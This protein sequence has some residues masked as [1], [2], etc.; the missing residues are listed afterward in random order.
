MDIDI[1]VSSKTRPLEIF[2][3]IVPASLNENGVLRKHNVGYYFQPIPIDDETGLSAITYKNAPN[4]NY[5]KIDIIPVRL[6]D[7]FSS[8]Q[9]LRELMHKEP[10]W[11]LLEERK[12]VEQ[13]FH[14]HD[15]FDIVYKIKPR[16]ILE[17]ADCLALIRPNK[18]KLIDKYVKSKDKTIIRKEL[19]KK[20]DPSDLRK[21]HAIPYAYLIIAQLNLIEREIT[22]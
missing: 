5:F 4:F 8:K 22:E 12:V 3:H 10:I 15:K 6:L 1:D 14:L 13:L 19:Y 11:E 20:H 18:V 7:S 2:D 16:N 9:E 17:L 21:S